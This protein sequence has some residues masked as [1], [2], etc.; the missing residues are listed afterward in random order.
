[1]SDRRVYL[2]R[3]AAD[4]LADIHAYIAAHDSP[5]RAEHVLT[6]IEQAVQSLAASPERGAVPRELAALGTREF[7]EVYFKPY[8]IV[9][10]VLD[11]RV[12]V[13][14]V[15]DGRRDMQSLLQR[16]LLRA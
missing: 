3:D 16:R 1:M 5:R 12:Y 11:E 9:Y 2:T 8:R 14:L 15:A 6:R 10:R 7:R 13:M 4:D